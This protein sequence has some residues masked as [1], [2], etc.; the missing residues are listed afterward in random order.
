MTISKYAKWIEVEDD[1][2]ALFN[3]ILMQVVFVDEKTLNDIKEYKVNEDDKKQLTEFGIY[4]INDD[5]LDEIYENLQNAVKTQSKQL[6][7]MYLN[8][9]T[10]CNLA[11]KYCFIENNPISKN[12]CQ[13]MSF[14]TAKIAVDKFVAEI[15][16]TNVEEPQ[17]IIYGGEPLTNFELLQEIVMYIRK[18]KKDLAVTVIT[19][20]TLLRETEIKFLKKHKIGIGISLDGPKFINDKNRVFKGGNESVYDSAIKGIEL[21]NK[22]GCNYCVSATVTKDVVDNKEAVYYWIKETGIKNIFWN[23]F[24]YSNYVDEKEWS[25]FYTSMS[26]FILDIYK[27]L[28]NIGVDEERVKEQL[29][30]FL[31]QRFKFHNCGAVGLNQITVQPNGNICICQGDSKSSDTLVGNIVA[32]DIQTILDNIKNKQWLEMYTIGREECR[33]CEAISICGGGCPLQSEAL[34]GNRKDLDKATCIYY[35]SS[36]KWLLKEYY[37]ANKEL[38]RE[39]VKA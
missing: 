15:T 6:S 20:G 36:L 19:N 3:S 18:I 28:D 31:E 4:V 30:L 34:F 37:V 1:V 33:Y 8:V 24:H 12:S 5:V 21:L 32:D 16:R 38:E 22:Y 7:I 35:K 11:C 17:I 9:S 27:K 23:L 10:F 13:K 39:E 29:K 26:D 25:S 14:D 2:Y